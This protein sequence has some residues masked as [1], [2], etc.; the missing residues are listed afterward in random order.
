MWVPREES[1]MKDQEEGR[2]S[3]KEML[4]RHNGEKNDG[5]G[6]DT[7]EGENLQGEPAEEEDVNFGGIK[8][9]VEE[10]GKTHF[11]CTNRGRRHL[12]RVWEKALIVK[13]LGRSTGV[14][15]M[16]K[17]IEEL[18]G[19]KG[20]VNVT[21]IGNEFY[22]EPGFRPNA[23]GI[24]K[25]AAWIRL[26]NIPLEFYDEVFFRRVGNW[27]EKL[28]KIDRTTNLHA[29]GRFA[30]ICVELDLAKPLKGEYVLEGV[31]K[32]IEY[33][34]LG[35]ICFNCGKYGHS[36]DC[37]SEIVQEQIVVNESH[38]SGDG[39]A[40]KVEENQNGLGPWMVVNRQRRPRSQ[41]ATQDGRTPMTSRRITQRDFGEN[42]AQ[43]KQLSVQS[44]QPVLNAVNTK[45][46]YDSL[47]VIGD[48]NQAELEV[49]NE[50]PNHGHNPSDLANNIGLRQKAIAKIQ[51]QHLTTPV[52]LVDRQVVLPPVQNTAMEV[53]QNVGDQSESDNGLKYPKAPDPIRTLVTT[54]SDASILSHHMEVD[55]G[56]I[57]EDSVEIVKGIDLTAIFEPRISGAKAE[58][59]IK[60]TGYNSCIVE[61]AQGFM[62]GIWVLWNKEF[63]NVTILEKNM[64]IVHLKVCF[65]HNVA[66]LCTFIYA[67]PREEVRRSVWQDLRRIA[68]SMNEPWLITD[69]FNEIASP[70]EKRGGAPVDLYKCNRF[71]SLLTDLKMIDLNSSDSR[72][73][74]RGPRFLNM[75]RVFKRLDRAC[76]NDLWRVT[77][78]E[79]YV[80]A[81]PRLKSDHIPLL[82]S[83]SSSKDDWKDCPFRFHSFWQDHILFNQ[84]LKDNWHVHGNIAD[85]LKVLT[86][87]IK[88]WN[89]K[90]FGNI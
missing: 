1:W 10:D 27:I 74:W 8:M 73:T 12:H 82:I 89:E 80:R 32:H 13:L 50:E 66:F 51:N 75:D 35:L 43:S 76:S 3:W 36:K 46:R 61:E 4:Q 86:P 5:E 11:G 40:D 6:A 31:L 72:F 25:I 38:P 57:N 70:F 48:L 2:I 7:L 20:K 28:I 69:D 39:E 34:G 14:S 71:A 49:I 29:R 84:F 65:F 83:L 45:S 41:A 59:I 78:E 67:N 87:C 81:L 16:K 58:K 42:T 37:C 30:R 26:P 85:C 64:Q 60:R 33:E 53:D 17:K 19:R 9:W 56:G 63:C 47:M 52:L 79:G 21:D 44:Y 24:S 54:H 90:V 15:F 18:W 55:K 68:D 22:V 23:E 62:G 77:F 88:E